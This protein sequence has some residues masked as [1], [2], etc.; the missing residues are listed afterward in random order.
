MVV[1]SAAR[2]EAEARRLDEEA[3]AHKTQEA[4]ERRAA[5]R[6]RQKADAVRAKLSKLGIRYVEEDAGSNRPT[7]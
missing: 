4:R 1:E 6:K 3:S 7:P 2:L 5:L